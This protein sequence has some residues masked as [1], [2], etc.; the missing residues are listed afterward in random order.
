MALI[1]SCTSPHALK[2]QEVFGQDPLES[3]FLMVEGFCWLVV[4]IRKLMLL[5]L[6]SLQDKAFLENSQEGICGD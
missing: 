2:H 5:G 6:Y 3:F 4:A 1:V